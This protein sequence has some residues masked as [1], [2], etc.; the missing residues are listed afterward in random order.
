MSATY[1]ALEPLRDLNASLDILTTTFAP[2]Y[3]ECWLKDKAPS[4]GD[5]PFDMNVGAFA[6]MWFSKAMRIFMAYG[7]DGKPVGYLLAMSFRPLTH[8]ASILQ[9]EDWYSRGDE[10]VAQGLF[11][12]AQTAA[13]FI[14]ADEIWVSHSEHEDVPPLKPM[15]RKRGRTIIERHVKSDG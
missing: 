6:Q 3:T 7:D 13:K 15:W 10:A 8:Q 1:D 4:R 12:Y 2:I 5:P 9:I 14:G 11:D